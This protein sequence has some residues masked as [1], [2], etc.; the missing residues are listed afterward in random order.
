M[1]LLLAFVLVFSFGLVTATPFGYDYLEH[2]A[3]EPI[4]NGSTYSINVNNTNYHQGLTPQQVAD[5]FDELDPNYFSNPNGYFNSSTLDV[6]DKL[7]TNGSNTDTTIN[8]QNVIT[9][10]LVTMNGL[11]ITNTESPTGATSEEFEYNGSGGGGIID[12]IEYTFRIYTYKDLGDFNLYSDN[13]TETTITTSQGAWGGVV[14]AVNPVPLYA[15]EGIGDYVGEYFYAYGN[16]D[17]AVVVATAVG[18]PYGD[19]VTEVAFVSGGDGY[20]YNGAH[21]FYGQMGGTIT[22]EVTQSTSDV[23]YDVNAN[24]TAVAGV[25]GYK[26]IIWDSY[27]GWVGDEFFLTPTN[28]F[29]I[30]QQAVEYQDPMV[31]TPNG[32]YATSEALRVNGG[33]R[34]TGDLNV[35]GTIKT[36]FG[37]L[38][39]DTGIVKGLVFQTSDS[40]VGGLGTQMGAGAYTLNQGDIAIGPNSYSI[41]SCT[42]IGSS[43]QCRAYG[44]MALNGGYTGPDAANSLAVGYLSRTGLNYATAI[45]TIARTVRGKMAL[46]TNVQASADNSMII[47]NGLTAPNTPVANFLSNSLWIGTQTPKLWFGDDGDF[48]IGSPRVI[49]PTS[50]GSEKLNLT[51]RNAWNTS[52][53]WQ[54][55]GNQTARGWSNNGGSFVFRD[56]TGA[57]KGTT[58]YQA[59][60]GMISK[61]EAGKTYKLSFYA[62]LASNTMT[63]RSTMA[64]DL[65]ST[66]TGTQN[67]GTVNVEDTLKTVEVYFTADSESSLVFTPN[68]LSQDYIIQAYIT[69]LTL[70]EI[71]GGDLE[72]LGT[73]TTNILDANMALIANATIGS[74][75]GNITISS[76]GDLK[77]NGNATQWED[78]T[79]PINTAKTTGSTNVPSFDVFKNGTYAYSFVAGDQIFATQQMSHSYK[80]NSTIYQHVHM[81][82]S[83]TNTGNVTICIEYTKADVNG[84]FPNTITSCGVK[85]MNGTNSQ[86]ILDMAGDIGSFSGLSGIINARIYRNATTTGSAYADKVFIL[87]YDLHYQKDSIGSNEEYVK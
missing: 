29:I 86:H 50:L 6:S 1:K 27:G 35:I 36:E 2:P 14:Q 25:D 71:T 73:T 33:A 83:S 34:I 4:I 58:L 61:I 66:S 43:T 10:G 42:S 38:L 65:V 69:D 45:G 87:A 59:P 68:T 76:E 75:T 78:M 55:W 11:G 77:L 57:V 37:D 67:L 21:T 3:G 64:F 30:S 15:D 56:D 7:F 39:S 22:V 8:F 24:W 12:P 32:Y 60:S 26:V 16:N 62:S 51:S 18:G 44:S 17:P 47:G 5:L 28:S 40:G 63:V 85:Y 46:G 20:I 72:V 31:I 53:T 49:D 23:L 80:L 82:P 84:I 54:T 81:T 70:K 9:N 13:Y 79:M 19:T 74:P 41:N 52:G 48:I